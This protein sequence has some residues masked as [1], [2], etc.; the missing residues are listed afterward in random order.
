MT[1]Q[2][3]DRPEYFLLKAYAV[4][5]DQVYARIPEVLQKVAQKYPHV[6]FSKFYIGITGDLQSRLE[7]H[8]KAAKGFL[9]MIPIYEEDEMPASGRAETSF[10]QLE[11]EAIGRFKGTT[12]TVTITGGDAKAPRPVQRALTCTNAVHGG[13][14]KRVLYVLVG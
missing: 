10:D 8:R 11:H 14:P 7:Q 4:T 12:H 2:L 13:M 1:L 5:P 6:A 3:I 9:Y